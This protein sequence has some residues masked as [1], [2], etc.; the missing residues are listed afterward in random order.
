MSLR[1]K[2]KRR[3]LLLIGVCLLAGAAAFW[4]FRNPGMAN[5][6][7][8]A[9]LRRSAMADYA[10]KDYLTAMPKLS[11][12]LSEIKINQKEPSDEELEALFAFGDCRSRITMPRQQHLREANQAFERY[13]SYRPNDAAA[14]LAHL[15]VLSKTPQFNDAKS[16]A[17]RILERDPKHVEALFIRAYSIYRLPK[18]KLDDVESAIT[19]LLKVDPGHVNGLLLSQQIQLQRGASPR[20]LIDRIEPLARADDK[21]PRFELVAAETYHM[22]ALSDAGKA[23]PVMRA[24]W[25]KKGREWLLKV[26][27]LP[28]TNAEF[29][30]MVGSSLDRVMMVSR[31]LRYLMTAVDAA[32]PD[33][34]NQERLR[35]S[36]IRRLW[37]NNVYAEVI[38]RTQGLDPADNHTDADLLAYRAITLTAQAASPS[39]GEDRTRLLNEADAITR[40]L[41]ARTASH[42]A[43]A[44]AI[45]LKLDSGEPKAASEVVR[46]CLEARE[47]NPDNAVVAV[48]LADAYAQ[49]GE[50]EA[51][52]QMWT[53]AARMSPD[54]GYPYARIAALRFEEGR[55]EEAERLADR[56][57]LLAP[58]NRQFV[59][60][61]AQTRYAAIPKN[62]NPAT[63][64]TQLEDIE[65]VQS[66]YPFESGTLPLQVTLLARIKGLDAA[67]ARLAEALAAKPPLSVETL[68]RLRTTSD[69]EKLAMDEQI[70]A[71]IG[72]RDGAALPMAAH[73]ARKLLTDGKAAEGL[74][75]LTDARK[76]AGGETDPRWLLAIAAYQEEAADPRAPQAWAELAARTPDDLYYQTQILRSQTRY[77]DR[78]LWRVTI[79][80]VRTL[81]GDEGTLW[82]LER[83]RW[84]LAGTESDKDRS[85]AI[86]L[87]TELTQRNRDSA[88]ARR[89]LGLALAGDR[90]FSRAAE[91]LAGALQ[92]APS[93]GDIGLELI[94]ALR[95]AG[96]LAGARTRIREVA[97]IPSLTPA[98]RLRIA[99]AHEDL[100]QQPE[101]IKVLQSLPEGGERDARLGSLFRANGQLDEAILA[102]KRVLNDV[103]ANPEHIFAGADFFAATGDL[104]QSQYFLDRLQT[105]PQSRATTE[106]LLGQF[107]EKYDRADD[108]L[109]HLKKATELEPK[110]P[111]AWKALGGFSLRSRKYDAAM[112]AVD[113]GLAVAPADPDLTA[114][115]PLIT[116]VRKL[117]DVEPVRLLVDFLSRQPTHPAA[118]ATLKVLAEGQAALMVTPQ[119][120][121]SAV[122]LATMQKLATLAEEYRDF[123]PLQE[124]VIHFYL[125]QK[126][127]DKAAELAERGTALSPALA[128]PPRLAS[129]C[130]MRLGRWDKV[131]EA[132]TIWRQR[133]AGDP[134]PADLMIAGAMLAKRQ[135][136]V[137]SRALEPHVLARPLPA[138]YSEKSPLDVRV[139]TLYQTYGRA[140]IEQGRAAEAAERLAPLLKLNDDCR[141]IWLSLAVTFKDEKSAQEWIDRGAAAFPAL[142]TI[143]DQ[144]SLAEACLAAG[145]PTGSAELLGRAAKVLQ[146]LAT[147]PKP[148]PEALRLAALTAHFQGD[149]IRSEQFWRALRKTQ[150]SPEVANNLAYVLLLSGR[151]Q[152]LAEAHQLAVEAT[153]ADPENP[154]YLGTLAR[155]HARQGARA[156]AIEAFRKVLAR[157]SQNVESMLGLAE[158]IAGSTPAERSEARKLLSE[159][160]TIMATNPQM[161]DP[162]LKRQAD[163][164]GALVEPGGSR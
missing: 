22:L 63:L 134:M 103:T 147:A 150:N 79:D 15:K 89:L 133:A 138:T 76:A 41:R 86:A 107:A 145:R 71:A 70:I 24:E 13:L 136:A 117:F 160:R 149:Y 64:A 114:L 94:D 81:T 161:S 72:T 8:T 162:E 48:R 51:A 34:E 116:T 66:A 32:R 128:D 47:K 100:G 3:L 119:E 4:I 52:V 159:A 21:D 111:L 102:Y 115:K 44:W 62:A 83:A 39:A 141:S 164:L 65:R 36:L 50:T 29:A 54:W 27:E 59:A 88:E 156:A 23:D 68:L 12:Y 135:P 26:V 33:D 49:Q 38:Q 142:P 110:N 10:K 77:R 69:T 56:A 60:L 120:K 17:E 18:P 11:Q 125:T 104:K 137:A 78:D 139:L 2:T 73:Q 121:Q 43:Q 126:R 40:A 148:L 82:K 108:A 132:A 61:L 6:A 154:V 99:A 46:R 113:A 98:Q 97:A 123:W 118:N 35:E 158:Q 53:W 30:I 74:K 25:D 122:A 37:Q 45:L 75:A 153:T 55:L 42:E 143:V 28:P 105:M 91:E 131:A 31:T 80:R 155:S 130:Y 14:Q 20:Q 5:A 1:A 157:D 95:K 19:D 9:E 109:V 87:L 92:M 146:P 163:S 96:D 101:A 112:S 57:R 93:R 7:Q 90:K 140:L 106:M 85:E 152:V 67:K 124:R 127:P 84:L 58:T 129:E 16:L 144:L 151:S